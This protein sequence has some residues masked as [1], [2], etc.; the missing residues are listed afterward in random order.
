MQK[1]LFFFYVD[2]E[3]PLKHESHIYPIREMYSCFT[4]NTSDPF[5]RWIFCQRRRKTAGGQLHLR[6]RLGTVPK[7]VFRYI[8]C[9]L[10][11]YAYLYS[12]SVQCPHFGTHFHFHFVG[13]AVKYNPNQKNTLIVTSVTLWTKKKQMFVLYALKE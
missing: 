12:S 8:S 11:S 7:S 9:R 6:K 5:F 4:N 2:V 13:G 10:F 1:P 3:N